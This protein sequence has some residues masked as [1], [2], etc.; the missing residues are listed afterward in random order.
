MWTR[1]V[2]QVSVIVLH[3]YRRG[4]RVE[5][6]HICAPPQEPMFVV[7]WDVRQAPR[8]LGGFEAVSQTNALSQLKFRART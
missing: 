3:T 4:V 1:V 7:A 8:E 6:T 5:G 2:H